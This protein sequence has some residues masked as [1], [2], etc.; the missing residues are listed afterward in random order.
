MKRCEHNCHL[1]KNE[2]LGRCYGRIHY[3]KDVSLEGETDVPICEEYIYG[4]S[5]EHLKEIEAA[6]SLKRKEDKTSEGEMRRLIDMDV[7]LSQIEANYDCDY[8]EVLLNPKQFLDL[9]KDQEII[10]TKTD[11]EG[12]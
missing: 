6:E 9:I 11:E 4:G 10:Y 2:W 3:G 12:V 7:L 5:E 8:G 1:C